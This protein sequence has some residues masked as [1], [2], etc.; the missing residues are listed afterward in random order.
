MEFTPKTATTTT[1]A[2][3]VLKKTRKLHRCA[4]RAADIWCKK[5][6]MGIGT[7]MAVR[8]LGGHLR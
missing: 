6:L 3:A 1:R 5:A 2:P 7:V 4:L 8:L